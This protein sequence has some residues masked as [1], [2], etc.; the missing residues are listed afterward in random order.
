MFRASRWQHRSM[1]PWW[2][3]WG[4]MNVIFRPLF[5]DSQSICSATSFHAGFPTS[6]SLS[7]FDSRAF[8]HCHIIHKRYRH[9]IAYLPNSILQCDFFIHQNVKKREDNQYVSFISSHNV[10]TDTKLIQ[11]DSL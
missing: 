11:L 2:I 1:S 4:L 10:C 8:A 3:L 9:A 6:L 5:W 7:L